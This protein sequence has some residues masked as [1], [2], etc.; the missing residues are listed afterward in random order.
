MKAYLDVFAGECLLDH[1]AVLLLSF[2]FQRLLFFERDLNTT[3]HSNG[4]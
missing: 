2:E 3:T 1:L 4:A